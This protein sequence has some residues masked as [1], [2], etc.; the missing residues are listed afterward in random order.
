MRPALT[1]AG[2]GRV[3]RR[4]DGLEEAGLRLLFVARR[5]AAPAGGARERGFECLRIDRE[6]ELLALDAQTPR[7]EARLVGLDAA[8]EDPPILLHARARRAGDRLDDGRAAIL[9]RD[10][11]CRRKKGGAE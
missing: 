11:R 2:G 7:G 8:F 4:A 9:L 3:G 10:R 1:R 6:Q 5:L